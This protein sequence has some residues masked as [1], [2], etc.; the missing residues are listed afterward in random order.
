MRRSQSYK[1]CFVLATI[2]LSCFCYNTALGAAPDGVAA[3]SSAAAAPVVACV[4]PKATFALTDK[5]VMARHTAQWRAN[6]ERRG[7][8]FTVSPAEH[9]HRIFSVGGLTIRRRSPPEPGVP[10]LYFRSKAAVDKPA[11]AAPRVLVEAAILPA[12]PL[13]SSATL[14]NLPVMRTGPEVLPELHT[15]SPAQPEIVPQHK[16]SPGAPLPRVL[17]GPTN[18][19]P[20]VGMPVVGMPVVSMLAVGA[21]ANGVRAEEPG[22]AA[23]SS[24]PAWKP[25]RLSSRFYV[26]GFTIAIVLIV[27]L[28]VA[29]ALLLRVLL[30]WQ[31]DPSW[32]P[33]SGLL[34]QPAIPTGISMTVP[35]MASRPAAGRG[36]AFA[37]GPAF[38]RGPQRYA[39]SLQAVLQNSLPDSVPVST[40][41]ATTGIPILGTW[42]VADETRRQRRCAQVLREAGW[43]TS[44][45]FAAGPRVADVIAT[46]GE[47][48]MALRCLPDT[49]PVD[50]QAVEEA[51]IARER[52]R[53]DMAV[54][55]SNAVGTA[56]ARKLAARTGIDLLTEDAL[57]ALVA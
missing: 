20:V 5:D 31:P 51:C 54:I 52:E 1:G 3:T 28:L 33:K 14:P 42:P 4:D 38:G 22:P 26:V 13:G 40:I 7:R 8:C 23:G 29:G 2:I 41:S 44:I 6:V 35:M 56:E 10:P 15:A 17:P 37:R 55:V 25:S 34:P 21:P 53:A 9:W 57:H 43:E 50:E 32:E 12:R 11:A 18:G 39:A 48:V 24:G 27:V 30:L 16:A 19:M 45:R 47:R 36:P 49:T 46:R